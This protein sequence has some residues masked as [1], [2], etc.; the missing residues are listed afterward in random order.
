MKKLCLSLSVLATGF[1]LAQPAL[2]ATDSGSSKSLERGKW[3]V[4]Y[5]G[6]NDCHTPGYA[7]TGGKVPTKEWLTGSPVGFKGPW[8][9]SYAANL[10][11]LAHDMTEAQWLAR[12]REPMLPPMP[13]FNLH[14]LND[15][16]LSAMYRFIRSLGPAGAPAPV[17]AKP[18]EP[19]NTP[20]IE[21]EP[22]NLPQQAGQQAAH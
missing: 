17:A 3:L 12:A 20:Y 6:C 11:L 18:G 16:D 5:G 8:G 10:R 7:Q 15:R 4:Q 2:S 13:W 1:M 21:F 22:K 9:T 19:V 14:Q